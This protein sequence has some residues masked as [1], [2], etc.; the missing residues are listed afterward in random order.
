VC[1]EGPFKEF[2][3]KTN[4]S[5][6][7]GIGWKY[8]PEGEC[9]PIIFEVNPRAQADFLAEMFLPCST[10]ILAAYAWGALEQGHQWE[11]DNAPVHEEL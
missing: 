8:A 10:S 9:R 1:V 5:G 6:W 4:Y 11:A 3:K 2:A 7:L